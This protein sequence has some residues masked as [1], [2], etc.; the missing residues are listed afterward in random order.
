MG[1]LHPD[2]PPPFSSPLF[3]LFPLVPISGSEW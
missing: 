3:H 1:L 2:P